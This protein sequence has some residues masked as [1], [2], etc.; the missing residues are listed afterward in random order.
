MALRKPLFFDPSELGFEEMT[1]ADSL[2]L[3]GLEMS[4]DISMKGNEVI[5]LPA[6]PSATGAASKEYVDSLHP[7]PVVGF[8]NGWLNNTNG[9]LLVSVGD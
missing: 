8:F 3:S 4:G 5:G 7:E 6:T 1:S 9:D 2:E